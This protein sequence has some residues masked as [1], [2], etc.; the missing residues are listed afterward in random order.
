MIYTVGEADSHHSYI[1]SNSNPIKKGVSRTYKGAIA[2]ENITEA[3][4]YIKQGS[5]DPS[6]LM[7][8]EEFEVY[9]LYGDWNQDT[10]QIEGEPFRRL[11]KD[12]TLAYIPPED[13]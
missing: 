2:F 13:D 3:E 11:N 4:K 9:Q 8:Y 6:N 12:L 7:C 10:Y 5:K 1:D